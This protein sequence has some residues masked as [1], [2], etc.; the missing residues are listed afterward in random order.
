MRIGSPRSRYMPCLDEL[1]RRRPAL[2]RHPCH[3]PGLHLVSSCVCTHGDAFVQLHG[4]RGA[5]RHH[6]LR[7]KPRR[8]AS[9][10][11]GTTSGGTRT[12]PAS[13]GHQ[14]TSLR[15]RGGDVPRGHRA[16]EPRRRCR[17]RRG[18]PPRARRG[19]RALLTGACDARQPR[20]SWT[21]SGSR[22]S[23][24]AG[25]WTARA[26]SWGMPERAASGHGEPGRT[27]L[28]SPR[29][30]HPQTWYGSCPISMQA[31]D[32]PSPGFTQLVAGCDTECQNRT[33]VG[34]CHT[35]I[36][37]KTQTIRAYAQS[38]L[39][40]TIPECFLRENASGARPVREKP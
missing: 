21:A 26:T 33:H 39:T 2:A 14:P 37:S 16:G 38:T 31:I 29:A 19:P 12:A 17:G 6:E 18:G 22:S 34:A 35:T 32:A 36:C 24:R 13:S 7:R 23:T 4:T 1:H 9:G 28:R 40:P 3:L 10:G 15:T 27:V 5:L 20:R 30:V 25:P 8:H 11:A